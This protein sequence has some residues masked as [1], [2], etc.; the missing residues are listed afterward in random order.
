MSYFGHKK[1]IRVLLLITLSLCGGSTYNSEYY[2]AQ[3]YRTING[4]NNNIDYPW[5][6]ASWQP[7][8]RIGQFCWV[9]TYNTRY[10]SNIVSNT[11][12]HTLSQRDSS[13]VQ[14][15]G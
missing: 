15:L 11:K 6:G 1:M 7:L 8:K 14:A 10:V 2:L 4:W 13:M 5:W 9:E 3:E 12:S